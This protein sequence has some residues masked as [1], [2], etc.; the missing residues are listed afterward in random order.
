VEKHHG[1]AC[2]ANRPPLLTIGLVAGNRILTGSD[3]DKQ[4]GW[5]SKLIL[6]P[7]FAVIGFFYRVHMANRERLV[8]LLR[9]PWIAM[10]IKVAV[11]LILILWIAVWLL[12]PEETRKELSKML[13]DFWAG[14]Q[15]SPK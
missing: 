13:T 2:G 10:A 6:G 9:R 1:S 5:W 7:I 14:F 15:S 11:M 4:N 12:T 8:R 3:M